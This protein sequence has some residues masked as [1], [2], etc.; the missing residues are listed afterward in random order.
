MGGD[1]KMHTFTNMYSLCKKHMNEFVVIET[2]DG[3][4]INGKI[5][6]L[7]NNH[8]HLDVPVSLYEKAVVGQW[9]TRNS[10][11]YPPYPYYPPY[12]IYPP[13]YRFRRLILPLAALVALSALPWGYY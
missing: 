1:N 5:V 2:I 10:R 7:D 13:G 9:G 11:I 6:G 12:P 4:K 3:Q 8:V